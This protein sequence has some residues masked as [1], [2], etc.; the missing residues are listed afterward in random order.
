[1]LLSAANI[2]SFSADRP[3]FIEGPFEET[4]T[5]LITKMNVATLRSASYLKK[6]CLGDSMFAVQYLGK[7][8]LILLFS[9][10][11]LSCARFALFDLSFGMRP[12]PGTICLR[13]MYQ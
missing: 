13:T 9:N 8:H 5:G 10:N 2:R 1:M 11:L 3:S 4:S 12:L 7:P 6:K